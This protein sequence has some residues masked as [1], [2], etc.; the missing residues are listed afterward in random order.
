LT[1]LWVH[2]LSRAP[3]A[4]LGAFLLLTAI[5][6]AQL[7]DFGAGAPRLRVETAVDLILPDHD[8][9]R[10]I[11]DH[12]R[13]RF[14]N[15][16]VVLLVL[17]AD[18]V[19][20][21]ENLAR[22]RRITER[23]GALEGIRRVVSVA[24][25]L[26]VR[27]SDD[28]IRVEPFLEEVP[29]NGSAL[30][31]LR[32]RVFGNPVYAGS[33]VSQDGRAS[34][35]LV[36]PEEMSE[37]EFRHRRLDHAIER[38]AAEE[39]GDVEVVL[40]G[41]PP[42]KATTSRLVLRDALF[43]TSVGVA[44]SAL[45]G[46]FAFRVA[47]G[48]L[49][50]LLS[51]AIGQL[52]ALGLM[53][54]L[55]RP[56]NLVTSIVPSVVNAV[57]V[58]YGMHLISEL[59]AVRHEGVPRVTAVWTALAQVA[60]PVLLCAF[61]AGAGFLSLCTSNLPAIREFGLF[62]SVGTIG[63]MAAALWLLP[64]WLAPRPP[65]TTAE[66]RVSRLPELAARC[67]R[68][69]LR[70]R[71]WIFATAGALVLVAAVGMTRIQVSTAL[72]ENFSPEHPL[73]AGFARIDEHLHGSNTLNV[74]I[75]TDKTD[76]FKSPERL[77]R[78]QELQRWLDAQPE[79]GHTTSIADYVGL[80]HR[81]FHGDDPAELRIPDSE[82]LVEQLFYFFWDEQLARF[83]DDDFATASIEVL[84]HGGSSANYAALLT[85]IERKLRELPPDMRGRATGNTVL[86]VHA[87]DDIARG[88]ALSLAT[89]LISIGGL[90]VLYFRSLR[91]GLLALVPNVLPVV[92]YF[93]ALG[94]F[95]VTLN[96]TTALVACMV[97]G[98]S[99][100]DTLHYLARYRGFRHAGLEP[101]KAVVESLRTVAR[102]IALTAVVLCGGLLALATSELRH[103]VEFGVLASGTLL[104]ALTMDLTLTPALATLIDRRGS[105][106]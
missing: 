20:T 74:V 7:W 13:E 95:G 25:A 22:I 65:R 5:A 51:V 91:I 15:D 35:L 57:G 47:W 98:V 64:C 71:G 94:L 26:D 28:G 106:S 62:C 44:I 76:A 1:R 27:A 93:G 30:A 86:V 59:E 10:R 69:D 102:P 38:V 40:G 33:L 50:P 4:W 41:A 55:D 60:S 88:Q 53:A 63:S 77:R 96:P 85:R 19:L 61:T 56:L 36:Y 37:T 2:L 43:S 39:R 90:L 24:N 87:L 16:E 52:W 101:E 103:Q 72:I 48:A 89:G 75:E 99:V 84:V 23:L 12:F 79:V 8:E 105:P 81:A 73:R 54:F 32:A 78:V 70:H 58:A 14:G 100:D 29:Q 31:A 97:L 21:T 18:D 3:R 104:L 68:F 45:V 82:R 49:L 34:V 11:Y 67:G 46:L 92:A 42:V 83:V 6:A 66:P 17:I 9:E 80:I